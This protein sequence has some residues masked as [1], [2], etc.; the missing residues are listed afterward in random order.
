M[1]LLNISELT[2]E[3]TSAYM[4]R[5]APYRRSVHSNR[6]EILSSF[7]Q[8]AQ[9]AVGRELALGLVHGV[10]ANLN[11]DLD[12][13][14]HKLRA[15]HHKLKK[16]PSMEKTILLVALQTAVDVNIADLMYT[17]EMPQRGA[18]AIPLDV[19]SGLNAPLK[20]IL[21]YV[22]QNRNVLL[23]SLGQALEEAPNAKL[24]CGLVV[25]HLANNEITFVDMSVASVIEKMAVILAL[26]LMVDMYL[27]MVVLAQEKY[28][29]STQ[30]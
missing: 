20:E 24:L 22:Q 7:D 30:N 3:A 26:Q 9:E 19:E 11:S 27:A 6:S 8:A 21:P 4:A 28:V 23:E 14:R 18:P 13:F 5:I 16:A 12:A 10:L 17:N 25:A 2:Q 29:K 15:Q 1:L